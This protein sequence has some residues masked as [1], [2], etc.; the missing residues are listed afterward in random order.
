[1]PRK[2][3]VVVYNDD[4]TTE[5]KTYDDEAAAYAHQSSAMKADLE[6]EIFEEG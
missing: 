4:G 2:Y 5:E 6:A 3:R 1:M